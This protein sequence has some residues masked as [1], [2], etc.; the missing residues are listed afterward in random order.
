VSSLYWFADGAFVGVSRPSASLAWAPTHSGEV[1]LSVVDDH[2]G[3]ATRNVRVGLI[4]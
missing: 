4:P 3:T 2:G 1:S